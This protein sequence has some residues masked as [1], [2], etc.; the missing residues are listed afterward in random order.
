MKRL[1]VPVLVVLAACGGDDKPARSELPGTIYFVEDVPHAQLVKLAGGTRTVI[2]RDLYP[3]P[4]TLFDGRIVAIAS[5]GDGSANSEQLALIGS[6]VERIGPAAAQLRD[7]AVDSRGR[8]VVAANFDGASN[9]Y[10][11]DLDGGITQLTNDPQGNFAPATIGESVVYVS[12]RDGDAE[13]YRD[14]QRLTAF[15]RDDWQPTPSPDGKTIAFLSDRDGT[16]HI[17]VM[18]SDGTNLRRLTMHDGEETSP[19][20]SRDGKQLAYTVDNQIW[21]RDLKTGND[22]QLTPP[23]TN[24]VEPSFSPD[25]HWLSVSRA[26]G[27]AS[28]VWVISLDSGEGQPVAQNARLPRWF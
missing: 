20:W 28:D 24:D 15:H 27:D 6:H 26:R 13:I 25:G 3:S 21:L 7:P 8:I 18:S 10:R 16:P 4:S 11:I 19:T 1:V 12:S 9:L 5:R 22:R 23:G 17:Y 2:G 14:Q